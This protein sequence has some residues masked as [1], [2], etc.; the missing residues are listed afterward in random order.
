[1]T[2]HTIYSFD[3]GTSNWRI[4]HLTAD[5]DAYSVPQMGSKLCEGDTTRSISKRREQ[6]DLL[7]NQNPIPNQIWQQLQP[8]LLKG[9]TTQNQSIPAVL[10]LDS[11]NDLKAYGQ[12]AYT[13]I[14]Q[15]SSQL[16]SWHEEFKL[17]ADSQS[18]NYTR[19]LL[20]EIIKQLQQE[21]PLSI[22]D[23]CLYIFSY[24][25][26]WIVNQ[27][28]KIL[29]QFISLV[30]E[31]FS[32]NLHNQ[33][34]FVPDTQGLVLGA[35][36]SGEIADVQDKYT[37][38]I[39]IGS[40]TIDFVFGNDI[41][42]NNNFSNFNHVSFSC[43]GLFD[44]ELTNYLSKILAVNFEDSE[45]PY[46]KLK[47]YARFIKENISQHLKIQISV[48]LELPGKANVVTK[49]LQ[50]TREDF[51]EIAKTS[52]SEFVNI[53]NEFIK[54]R[55]SDK[56]IGQIFLSGGGSQ[57]YIIKEKLQ[58]IF[59]DSIPII[60]CS[61]PD[62]LLVFSTALWYFRDLIQNYQPVQYEE[63]DAEFYN[64]ARVLKLEKGDYG[65]A[66]NELNK[67][68]F[69][70][71]QARYQ[72]QDYQGTIEDL[73]EVMRMNPDDAYPY[74]RYG[75]TQFQ[76]GD[77]RKAIRSYDQALQK[78]P[79]LV[80]AY[81][82]RGVTRYYL[83][84]KRRARD[85]F[86][87]A[88]TM[89]P[90]LVNQQINELKQKTKKGFSIK[91][92]NTEMVELIEFVE[93]LMKR[94]GLSKPNNDLV[95]QLNKT[96]DKILMLIPVEPESLEL[97]TYKAA[98]EYFVTERP[99]TQ[100]CKKAALLR[101]NHHKGYLV[102]QVF[103]DDKNELVS[104]PNNS[105]DGRRLIVKNFDDELIEAFAGTNLIVIE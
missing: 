102:A 72:L 56:N 36:S 40:T 62:K 76:Q 65:G 64:K 16:F 95:N 27:E 55:L 67:A 29:N 98:I 12:E 87:E 14:N 63:N 58:N 57:L 83:G 92:R 80:E 22:Q 39:D 74:Y 15:N 97:L 49:N 37:L 33:I 81:F 3:C 11:N 103:I 91:R 7:I 5:C 20:H 51:K 52:I 25:T 90:K 54:T 61:Q 60:N 70:R 94:F 10:L 99:R 71:S 34:H 4:A 46:I 105:P 82:D 44:D 42:N 73:Q 69:N 89:S 104:R 6:S 28:Q 41:Y 18:L 78:N 47:Q 66:I 93:E 35:L 9:F 88:I 30:H 21:R 53:V 48:A 77:Y 85:D 38:I 17:G 86:N 101:Q 75:L 32:E 50:I 31:S 2:V 43:P 59:G 96:I 79:H 24:P 68:Y 1:M 19:I 13:K 84:D 26:S 100:E 23:D 8:L 45:I